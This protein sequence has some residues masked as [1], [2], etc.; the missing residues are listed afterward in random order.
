MKTGFI[1][2]DKL[3]GFQMFSRV[4]FNIFEN[5]KMKKT[6]KFTKKSKKNMIKKM[7][8]DH[9]TFKC[10]ALIR[11]CKRQRNSHYMHCTL[12]RLQCF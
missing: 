9:V 5:F 10:T 8:C 1:F 12:K 2:S 11:L 6:E 4:A 3:R 7:T